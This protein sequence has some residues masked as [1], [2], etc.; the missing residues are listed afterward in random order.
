MMINRVMAKALSK[1]NVKVIH[2][3]QCLGQITPYTEWIKWLSYESKDEKQIIDFGNTE[4]T[5]KISYD[6]LNEVRRINRNRVMANLFKK[7]GTGE[8]SKKEYII[9]YDYMCTESIENLMTSKL[10]PK[11]L[12]YAKEKIAH[13]SSLPEAE[14]NKKVQEQQKKEIYDQL[15]MVDS[16]ILHMLS[17][18]NF[19][20]SL[21]RLNNEIGAQISANEA[22]RQKS[23][24]YASRPHSKR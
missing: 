13:Y 15:S 4:S 6:E 23:L 18:I 22:M 11:E 12:S 20:R 9:V 8:C 2:G 5:S 21:K 10:S 7:Y 3:Q 14:L 1:S 17:K 19:A 16:Y 24:Y